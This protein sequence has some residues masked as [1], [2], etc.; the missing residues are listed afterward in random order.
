METLL[1]GGILCLAFVALFTPGRRLR[2]IGP[3]V[4]RVMILR[5]VAVPMVNVVV[6][7]LPV[8]RHVVP[9]FGWLFVTSKVISQGC[10]RR[11]IND[12]STCVDCR[13][14]SL[15]EQLAALRAQLAAA[16]ERARKAEAES[17]DSTFNRHLAAARSDAVRDAFE[18]L[19]GARW[20]SQ[21][22]IDSHARGGCSR[23]LP[24]LARRPPRSR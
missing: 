3:S 22:R 10:A 14:S 4:C 11:D 12:L 20:R 18:W 8:I 13:I 6:L 24:I 21:I 1:S 15:T 23:P 7:Y 2:A 16:E 17:W 9:L 19:M 5:A